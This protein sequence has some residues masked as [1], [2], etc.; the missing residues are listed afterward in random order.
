MGEANVSP[1]GIITEVRVSNKFTT[2]KSEF[3]YMSSE[4]T[5]EQE[6]ENE[7]E[8]LILVILMVNTVLLR[9][10]MLVTVV[11]LQLTE[12]TAVVCP[13]TVVIAATPQKILM[14]ATV[15]TTVIL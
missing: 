5:R 7:D 4:R 3:Q 9:M 10:R 11:D 1:N 2:A 8:N 13:L 12:V 14:V 6:S 15:Q